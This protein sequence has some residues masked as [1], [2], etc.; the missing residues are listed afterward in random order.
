MRGINFIQIFVFF[1]ITTVI[2]AVDLY[3][4]LE[5]TPDASD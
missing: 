3:K 1:S 5:L 4:V 2:I